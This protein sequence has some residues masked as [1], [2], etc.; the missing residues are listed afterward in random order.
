MQEKDLKER[1]DIGDKFLIPSG[2]VCGNAPTLMR[3]RA[4]ADDTLRRKSPCMKRYFTLLPG[5]R[6]SRGSQFLRGTRMHR[7]S[8][9]M[10]CSPGEGVARRGLDSH[11]DARTSCL[12]IS[13]Y[14]VP[15]YYG[16]SVILLTINRQDVTNSK[17]S[18]APESYLVEH[19]R[20]C[21]DHPRVIS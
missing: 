18:A 5:K 17:H 20:Q 12:T 11:Q 3:R 9:T 19:F 14:F 13:Y 10:E 2:Y 1:E 6:P 4:T 8:G 7:G 15:P 16:N 21:R